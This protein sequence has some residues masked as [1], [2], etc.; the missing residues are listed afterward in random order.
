VRRSFAILVALPLTFALLPLAAV[1]MTRGA[2]AGDTTLVLEESGSL[3]A[4]AA[5]AG[6]AAWDGAEFGGRDGALTFRGADPHG[7]PAGGCEEI[8]QG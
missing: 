2:P 3:A 7:G 1:L 4:D 5:S 8:P 6:V